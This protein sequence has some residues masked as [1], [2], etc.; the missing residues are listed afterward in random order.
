MVSARPL[1]RKLTNTV[2]ARHR[3]TRP[4]G[5]L[6]TS[7][8]LLKGE[9]DLPLFVRWPIDCFEHVAD[10]QCLSCEMS[11]QDPWGGVPF[12]IRELENNG[13][14]ICWPGAASALQISSYEL[15][16]VVRYCVD[17]LPVCRSPA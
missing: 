17:R 11:L 13:G 10:D 4:L 14:W 5:T 7:S 8:F 15:G 12:G 16:G 3:R 2:D 1:P 9:G 6:F